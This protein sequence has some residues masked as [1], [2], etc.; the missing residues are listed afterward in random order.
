MG[1]GRLDWPMGV[2]EVVRAFVEMS[3]IGP[4]SPYAAARRAPLPVQK[5]TETAGSGPG[6]LGASELR[7]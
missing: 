7:D 2:A 6:R 1:L 3:L 5:A 4:V